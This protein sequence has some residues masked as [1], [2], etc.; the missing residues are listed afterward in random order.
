MGNGYADYDVRNLVKYDDVIVLFFKDDSAWLEFKSYK[1]VLNDGSPDEVMMSVIGT[2]SGPVTKFRVKFGGVI[3]I[4]NLKT[5]LTDG[6]KKGMRLKLP[7]GGWPF[8]ADQFTFSG[9]PWN[10]IA[11]TLGGKLTSNS[12]STKRALCIFPR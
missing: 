1:D 7:E 5:A 3:S 10:N 8:P 2:V 4:P 9:V 11:N 6:A 12:P